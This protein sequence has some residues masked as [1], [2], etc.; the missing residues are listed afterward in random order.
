M[1]C[2]FCDYD[3]RDLAVQICPECGTRFDPD[4]DQTFF[5]RQRPSAA[6]RAAFW[7]FGGLTMPLCFWAVLAIVFSSLI[8]VFGENGFAMLAFPFTILMTGFLGVKLII[9]WRRR[10]VR[11]AFTILTMMAAV[12]FAAFVLKFLIRPFS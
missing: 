11:A 10:R 5:A 8:I 2:R 3:L 1:Y 4:V 12:G 6:Q 7:L 9:L